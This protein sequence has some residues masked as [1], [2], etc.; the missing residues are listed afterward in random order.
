MRRSCKPST[1]VC[2]TGQWAPLSVWTEPCFVI[3]LNWNPLNNNHVLPVWHLVLLV[4]VHQWCPLWT[5][6]LQRRKVNDKQSVQG[7]TERSPSLPRLHHHPLSLLFRISLLNSVGFD[8]S[9]VF[10]WG[11]A[12]GSGGSQSAVSA[13]VYVATRPPSYSILHHRALLPLHC[14]PH[15]HSHTHMTSSSCT[16]CLPSSINL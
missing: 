16:L 1:S 14:T 2:Q 5:D 6:L 9:G 4:P 7:W 15:T 3:F 13:A 12:G 10:V 8:G 11:V